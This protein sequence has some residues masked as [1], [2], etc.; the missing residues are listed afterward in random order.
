MAS[1]ADWVFRR[2]SVGGVYWKG[3]SF[4]REIHLRW[5]ARDEMGCEG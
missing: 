3:C 4:L 5:D 2:P 1:M